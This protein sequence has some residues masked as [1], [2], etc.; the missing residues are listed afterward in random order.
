LRYAQAL[1][2]HA[3]PSGDLAQVLDRA[4][5]SLIAR[6]EQRR[7]AATARTR[8]SRRRRTEDTRYVPAAIRR[9]VW[10]RDGGRCTFVSESGHRCEAR[11]CLELDHIDPVARGGQTTPDRMRLCCRAHNQYTAE[12]TFGTD[13]MR[14][15]RQEARRCSAAARERRAREAAP[16]LERE[17]AASRDHN[18]N[19]V[20]PWLRQ[21]GFRAEE[22][23]RAAALCEHLPDV[24]LE[25]RV[26]S[27]LSSLAPSSA[28][29]VS[30]V[31]S[32]PA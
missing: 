32:A 10:Q 5:D 6:L 28:R 8:P 19:D 18:G 30:N 11:T 22:A 25:V 7:F 3:L 29:R 23:R 12:R 24:P 16:A 13:F 2:G 9:M 4:L 15:K 27:A 20:V 21:L 26:R 14:H 1:L 31:T 17:H